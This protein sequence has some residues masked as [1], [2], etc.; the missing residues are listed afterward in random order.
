VAKKPIGAI[1]QGDPKARGMLNVTV[2]NDTAADFRGP[3]VVTVHASSDATLDSSDTSLASLTKTL[4]LK[5]GQARPVAMK[6]PL[7][8]APTGDMTLLTAATANGVSATASGPAVEVREPFVRLVG[9]GAAPPPKPLSFDRPARFSLNLRNDGNVAVPGSPPATYSLAVTTM[10]GATAFS[11]SVQG[12]VRLNA[13]QSRR[14]A[15][16][17]TFPRQ[18]DPGSYSLVVNLDAPLNETNG[19]TAATIPFT[20]A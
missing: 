6:V 7:A 14:Q 15:F 2:R 17:V 11:T 8:A 3:V 13:G 19:Q 12:T 10:G 4:R 9:A 20:I 1:V 16:T 5:P 18:F